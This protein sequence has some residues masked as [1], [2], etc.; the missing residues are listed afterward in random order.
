VL[1]GKPMRDS[2]STGLV[3][4]NAVAS[5]AATH[6]RAKQFAE[7][8]WKLSV[9]EGRYRYYDGMLYLMTLLHCSGEFGIWPLK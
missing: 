1:D 5:L 8:L 3:S 4:M 7:E 2:H 9:P 6:P